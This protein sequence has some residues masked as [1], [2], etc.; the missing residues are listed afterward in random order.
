M[1][2]SLEE[3]AA[4]YG[5]LQVLFGPIFDYNADGLNDAYSSLTL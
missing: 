4:K 5:T 1:L 2:H 3:Y